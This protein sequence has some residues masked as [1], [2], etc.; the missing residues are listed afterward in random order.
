MLDVFSGLV[1][2]AKLNGD[3]QK[4]YGKLVGGY[5]FL[6]AI[7]AVRGRPEFWRGVRFAVASICCGW[8]AKNGSCLLG[9]ERVFE[10]ACRS[11][12]TVL[13]HG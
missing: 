13:F 5:L 3:F 8:L 1:E 11:F 9:I 7:N 2:I 10:L 12:R 4:N 6:R